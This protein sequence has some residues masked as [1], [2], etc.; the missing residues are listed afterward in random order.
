MLYTDGHREALTTQYV[1]ITGGIGGS[2]GRKPLAP[3]QRPHGVAA[4][5]RAGCR[6]PPVSGGG[7]GDAWLLG[8]GPHPDSES[9]ADYRRPGRRG[10]H[11]RIAHRRSYP[12]SEFGQEAVLGCFTLPARHSASPKPASSSFVASAPAWTMPLMPSP[13]AISTNMG[14]S[15][16]YTTCDGF[17][18]AMSRAMR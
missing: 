1:R 5:L 18:W 13:R 8:P 15:S 2:Y 17:T 4:I 16:M 10:E 6:R 9:G 3:L 12:V 11:P 7:D 14:R